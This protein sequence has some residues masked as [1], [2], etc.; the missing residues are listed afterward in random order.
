VLATVGVGLGEGGPAV[1]TSTVLGGDTAGAEEWAGVGT[2]DI[3]GVLIS[4]AG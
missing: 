1:S 2:E 3:F 4:C